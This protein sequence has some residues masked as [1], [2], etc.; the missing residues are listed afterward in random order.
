MLLN[1]FN[2]ETSNRFY[3]MYLKYYSRVIFK[4]SM[5]LPLVYDF[6]KIGFIWKFVILQEVMSE[7]TVTVIVRVYEVL[8]VFWYVC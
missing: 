6:G 8:C 5:I 2:K 1:E 7:S 3:L 4:S